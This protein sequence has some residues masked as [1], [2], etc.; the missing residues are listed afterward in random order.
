[1][2]N[3]GPLYLGINQPG[4]RAGLARVQSK[5]QR[6]LQTLIGPV[7]RPTTSRKSMP[8]KTWA[9]AVNSKQE[10]KHNAKVTEIEKN[11]DSGINGLKVFRLDEDEADL[12]RPPIESD[13]SDDDTERREAASIKPT[14]FVPAS[15]RTQQELIVW[16]SRSEEERGVESVRTWSSGNKNVKTRSNHGSPKRKNRDISP[17]TPNKSVDIFENMVTKKK[18]RAYGKTYGSSQTKLSS[19]QSGPKATPGLS[20]LIPPVSRA[21]ANKTAQIRHGRASERQILVT[22]ELLT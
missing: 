10:G 16:P 19:S 3:P 18:R 9:R 5:D 1:M 13:S 11:E 15:Q 6:L 21:Q 2:S 22:L 12:R 7:E 17:P 20:I 4:R 14:K 8:P